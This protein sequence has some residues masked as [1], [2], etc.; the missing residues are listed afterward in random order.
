[1]K[2]VSGY[3]IYAKL[4]NRKAKAKGATI[5]RGSSRPEFLTTIQWYIHSTMTNDMLIY[6]LQNTPF[7]FLV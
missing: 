6:T 7:V 5:I 1:M 3:V 2:S 4:M